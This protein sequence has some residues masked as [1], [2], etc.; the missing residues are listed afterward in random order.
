MT[1]R[2]LRLRLIIS[3]YGIFLFYNIVN[4]N[5]WQRLRSVTRTRIP[6][7][8]MYKSSNIKAQLDAGLKA[9]HHRFTEACHS[10]EFYVL[11][12]ISRLSAG[13]ACV[14]LSAA[15][16]YRVTGNMQGAHP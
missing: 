10:V 11:R 5:G 9:L 12:K 14:C 13:F 2:T 4:A 3:A 8:C 16:R 15:A 7:V 1:A 6:G